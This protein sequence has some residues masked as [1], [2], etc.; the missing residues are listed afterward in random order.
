MARALLATFFRTFFLMFQFVQ[1]L[2]TLGF[3]QLPFGKA[4]FRRLRLWFGFGF[5]FRN[6]RHFPFRSFRLK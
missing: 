5:R 2:H 4:S 3:F 1:F 6:L